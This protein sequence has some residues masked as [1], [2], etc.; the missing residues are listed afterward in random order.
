MVETNTHPQ[1]FP[2]MTTR[3]ENTSTGAL[4]ARSRLFSAVELSDLFG[5]V[6][7][8][9]Q[10]AG[11]YKRSRMGEIPNQVIEEIQT[12]TE[13]SQPLITPKKR[14]RQDEDINDAIERVENTVDMVVRGAPDF[15]A[16]QT[17]DDVKH[18]LPT[19]PLKEQSP[20]EIRLSKAVQF[21]IDHLE[22]G[23]RME[24][25]ALIASFAAMMGYTRELTQNQFAQLSIDMAVQAII[26]NQYESQTIRDHL[27]GMRDTAR[28]QGH[29]SMGVVQ[30]MLMNIHYAV[31]YF[32]KFLLGSTNKA[33]Y[34]QH[35]SPYTRAYNRY[36]NH[37]NPDN[38][39][40]M[41]F[42]VSRTSTDINKSLIK[43]HSVSVN[44]MGDKD[45]AVVDYQVNDQ[46]V[47]IPTAYYNTSMV[48]VDMG[49][50]NALKIVNMPLLSMMP[51]SI[52][53][54]DVLHA[55][56]NN[57]FGR[58]DITSLALR[59]VKVFKVYTIGANNRRRY[60]TLIDGEWIFNDA[61]KIIQQKN[62]SRYATLLEATPNINLVFDESIKQVWFDDHTVGC[63][64]Y[65][66]CLWYLSEYLGYGST[67]NEGVQ[68]ISSTCDIGL[69]KLIG[70]ASDH[71]T[72]SRW[73]LAFYKKVY[74]T[75]KDFDDAELLNNF[76]FDEDGKL[77]RYVTTGMVNPINL[78]TEAGVPYPPRVKKINA[79]VD[80]FRMADQVFEAVNEG[81][82][83][84]ESLKR[85][86]PEIFCV[87]IKPKA[88]VFPYESP[89]PCV[90]DGANSSLTDLQTQDLNSFVRANAYLPKGRGIYV[91]CPWASVPFGFITSFISHN[92]KP[93]LPSLFARRFET[94]TQ[95][96]EEELNKVMIPLKDVSFAYGL[97]DFFLRRVQ[98]LPPFDTETNY[99]RNGYGCATYA[100]NF[101]AFG[102]VGAEFETEEGTLTYILD[103]TTDTYSKH[104]GAG[105]IVPAGAEIFI[106]ADGEKAE[107][108]TDEADVMAYLNA[109]CN[110]FM[111]PADVSKFITQVA[112][113]GI[114]GGVG[115]FGDRQ[116]NMPWQGSG[117]QLT[118]T[119]NDLKMAQILHHYNQMTDYGKRHL[120]HWPT[121]KEIAT[122]YGASIT[123]ERVI[124]KRPLGE[125]LVN[126]DEELDVD[127]LGLSAVIVNGSN[128]IGPG[129]VMAP[130]LA[131][132]R[133]LK[134]LCFSKSSREE[135]A[136]EPMRG[137]DATTTFN[138]S[139]NF[140]V[141][142][143]S[144]LLAGCVL[145]AH[146]K[147]ICYNAIMLQSVALVNFFADKDHDNK[148]KSVVDDFIDLN[149]L[150]TVT[151]QDDFHSMLFSMNRTP[152]KRDKLNVLDAYFVPKYI[153]LVSCRATSSRRSSHL[154]QT[155]HLARVGAAPAMA[156]NTAIIG[157]IP[158]LQYPL[159]KENT[160]TKHRV[161]SV[162]VYD[163]IAA[164]DVTAK[165]PWPS[166]IDL[167]ENGNIRSVT[168]LQ[169]DPVFI[170]KQQALIS[171]RGVKD[172]T[173]PKFLE[174]F[175][176]TLRWYIIDH[177]YRSTDYNNAMARSKELRQRYYAALVNAMKILKR[178]KIAKGADLPTLFYMNTFADDT[179][180]IS[181]YT[182]NKVKTMNTSINTAPSER[183]PINAGRDISV[184]IKQPSAVMMQFNLSTDPFMYLCAGT[185]R[186]P[187]QYL[188]AVV[189]SQIAEFRK[190]MHSLSVIG[191]FTS[192]ITNEQF[193]MN[194]Y[195]Q[196]LTMA[197]GENYEP[198][199]L[200]FLTESFSLFWVKPG[201]TPNGKIVPRPTNCVDSVR[202]FCSRPV[203]FSQYVPHPDTEGHAGI[204]IPAA[205]LLYLS[206]WACRNRAK[207]SSELFA[208]MTPHQKG[209][210]KE[211][212]KKVRPDFIGFLMT[213]TCNLQGYD[214][215]TTIDLDKPLNT[216]YRTGI[217]P[218][219]FV[220]GY[221]REVSHHEKDTSNSTFADEFSPY[222][223]KELKN[224][225]NRHLSQERLQTFF[226]FESIP[227]IKS[228]YKQV[229]EAMPQEGYPMSVLVNI[230]A[231]VKSAMLYNLLG[232]KAVKPLYFIKDGKFR[233]AVGI[234]RVK[235]LPYSSS[236]GDCVLQGLLASQLTDSKVIRTA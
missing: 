196:Y 124:Y 222:D 38:S 64:G 41:S 218:N 35:E 101:Y 137:E 146:E 105:H 22:S 76:L 3:P 9:A 32:N 68:S 65:Q 185:F 13:E 87:V 107:S 84:L 118:F 60:Q 235:T 145:E 206:P 166:T 96:Y 144:L 89:V 188:P 170:A 180:K 221:T 109:M 31:S 211:F 207:L 219:S 155:T 177:P 186:S 202:V 6:V 28:R 164:L 176:E 50:I 163:A 15:I 130:V 4:S 159:S 36:F 199:M 108:A 80:I 147:D 212:S 103:P 120:L 178:V 194:I 95:F 98:C 56:R 53:C 94:E 140:A 229:I 25:P 162:A 233:L 104:E 201:P 187:D 86:F 75:E 37:S 90:S 63:S 232:D 79:L 172:Q 30:R 58:G 82:M 127:I 168:F 184:V 66:R 150:L 226:A 138:T 24:D 165:E 234:A 112:S 225:V 93:Y 135:E 12:L 167:G 113:Y 91:P 189:N 40:F 42:V 1:K 183:P 174:L 17:I 203:L 55:A 154:L 77:Y 45:I 169:H 48:G 217:A 117:N 216:A 204:L 59:L 143:I 213:L 106:S 131:Y 19:T 181:K 209:V 153:D 110:F 73:I 200:K 126:I 198:L 81:G 85:K 16:K 119:L 223:G 205:Q 88:E 97:F 21:L 115:I 102:A 197:D 161:P 47:T 208:K 227:Q 192:V 61:L 74:A 175:R 116:I 43:V 133:R 52:F 99:E 210:L 220:K 139:V 70:F 7:N 128:F 123:L 44:R 8:E 230:V 114:A 148:V 111:I 5:D 228:R 33:D 46:P 182:Q 151:H 34:H 27:L 100:D 23:G 215:V 51:F 83:N 39:N 78:H 179:N 129:P 122:Y 214:P 92:Y 157:R 62:P 71:K 29:V 67:Y 160:A 10:G 171:A 236:V 54:D 121:M 125:S 141:K 49:F 193:A 14:P 132:E 11:S 190:E 195:N 26:D 20:R 18:L 72:P 134:A 231:R 142:S 69:E 136:P 152:D 57:Y 149:T 158:T 173:L 191:T 2:I 224:A 156:T